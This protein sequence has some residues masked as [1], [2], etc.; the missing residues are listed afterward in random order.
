MANEYGVTKYGFIKKSADQ[1]LLDYNKSLEAEFPGIDTSPDEPGGQLIGV[2]SKPT[3]NYW[4]ILE[5]IYSANYLDSA[6][7]I[8]LDKIGKI[9]DIPRL[10]ASRSLARAVGLKGDENTVITTS[11]T[12]QTQVTNHQFKAKRSVTITLDSSI[13]VDVIVSNVQNTAQYYVK[14]NEITKIVTSD[15]DAT[16]EEIAQLLVQVINAD[17]S[18]LG[19]SAQLP[20]TPDGSFKIISNDLTQPFTPEFDAK[21]TVN[22]FWTPADFNS[23]EYGSIEAPTGSLTTIVTPVAGLSAVYNFQDA[24]P[25]RIIESDADYRQRIKVEISRLGGGNLEAI[26]ARMYEVEDVTHVRGFEN[27]NNAIDSE[28]RP[29]HSI[30]II[31]Q[32]GN[33]QDIADKLWLIKGGGIKTYG[34]VH[35]TVVDSNG[36]TQDSN[37]SRPEP[38]YIWVKAILTV[39]DLFPGDGILTIGNNILL[40]GRTFGIADE[41]IYQKFYCPIYSVSGVETAVLQL[42]VTA[43]PSETPSYVTTNIPMD[44][45]QIGLF[46]TTRIE[47]TVA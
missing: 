15:S 3:M 12:I 6:E 18:A 33:N 16:A 47:V 40:L 22:E 7:G 4:E 44:D 9:V 13:V 17:T 42:A 21:L 43:T 26:V 28:G 10:G 1:I 32:G 27:R 23:V 35:L 30:E 25:G 39:T 36:K 38:R 8:A 14:I 45:R 34:N 37:F 31:V 5:G 11:L 20:S 41:I 19:V 24:T 46:D 2:F 29:G